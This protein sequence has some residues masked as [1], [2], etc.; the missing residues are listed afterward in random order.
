MSDYGDGYITQSNLFNSHCAVTDAPDA[1]ASIK[2]LPYGLHL[3]SNTQCNRY[4]YLFHILIKFESILYM[5][6]AS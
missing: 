2:A 6:I 4:L 3:H 1:N 5:T